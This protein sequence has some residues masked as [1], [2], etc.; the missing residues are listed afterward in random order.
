MTEQVPF[1]LAP[2][3]E[4]RA[5]EIEEAKGCRPPVP[6]LGLTTEQAAQALGLSPRTLEGWRVRGGGPRFAKLTRGVVRYRI[7]DLCDWLAE[8]V[9]ANT[10]QGDAMA[11]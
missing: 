6:V 4:T 10:A 7:E 11:A 2:A 5:R 3:P 1:P 9:V 8:R